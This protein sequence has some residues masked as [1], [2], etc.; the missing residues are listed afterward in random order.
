MILNY[1]KI[2]LRLLARSP[3]Y[4][5]I[6]L[7]GLSVG[8]AV[9][10]VLQQYSQSQLDSDKQWK[11]AERIARLGF[12]WEWTDDGT[13][14]DSEI[15]SLVDTGS[16]VMLTGDFPE[17]ES[18]TRILPQGQFAEAYVGFGS[19][20]ITA[21]ET[22]NEKR[23]FKEEHMASADPNV[24]E[25][26]DIPF[27]FG[28]RRTA[29]TMANA[30]VINQSIAKKYFGD[31][32]PLGKIILVNA[33][34]YLVAGVF[35]DFP[36]NTHLDF[37]LVI[38]NQ[39]RIAHWNTNRIG[40]V[41]FGYVKTR[42]GVDWLQFQDNLNNPALKEK[43]WAEVSRLFPN[44]RGK[45]L[46]ETLADIPFSS[47]HRFGEQP[48]K[49][50]LLLRAFQIIGI[51]V[52]MLAIINYLS[53]NASRISNRFKEIATR[54]VSGARVRDFFYQ[55]MT[56]TIIV[57]LIAIAMALTIVQMVKI[58]F[59]IWLQIP[60]ENVST[61]SM[62]LLG[63]V[64][65]LVL[66]VCATYPSYLSNRFKPTALLAKSSSP[67]KGRSLL[68]L[69]LFQYAI[70]TVLLLISVLFFRQITFM[71][72][73]DLGFAKDRV[74]VI[75]A[76]LHR[77]E[78]FEGNMTSFQNSILRKAGVLNSTL[79]STV[80]GD[81][82]N[83]ITVRQRGVEYPVVLDG[84]GG[85]DEHFIPC[86]ELK[87]LAGRNFSPEEK[88]NVIIISEGALSRLGYSD[89]ASAIGN[90]IDVWT[91]TELGFPGEWRD[92]EI[93]GVVKGYRLRPFFKYGNEYDKADR[94]MALTY[95][96]TV[97]SALGPERV[98]LRMAGDQFEQSLSEIKDTFERFFPGNFFHWYFLDDHISRHYESQKVSRNQILFFTCLAIAIACLGLL[99]M[100]SNKVIEKTKE[101]GIR[102][103]LGAK[104]SNIAAVLLKS[105]FRQIIL[106][107]MVSIPL[108]WYLGNSY[109]ENFTE[110]VDQ[111]WWH[112]A[113]PVLVLISIMFMTI[114]S[115]V[116]KAATTN[117]VES[118]RYE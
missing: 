45:F 56:E 22:G 64:T 87:L 100:I 14:W 35:A 32:D 67:K 28:D 98:T 89:P 37:E 16:P 113:L 74:V 86:Y 27:L 34:A 88:G 63:I 61:G 68:S 112:Y 82:P 75:D 49:S 36:T 30:I 93:I 73:K 21:V 71:L 78:N 23:F 31:N 69:S 15:F 25:F 13:T 111:Q 29:L 38:S 53:L 114:A 40:P 12:F 102:K 105:T 79:S 90:R 58:P 83:L 54:K 41:C 48:P 97:V 104:V 33:N 84:N 9:F 57:F 106:S 77:D 66:I 10:F 42:T 76:P 4:T 19:R 59:A 26:F 17:V 3:F 101:I 2:A 85:V 115:L 96:S 72:N 20:V 117:P 118:L 8:F 47:W 91:A 50:K 70:A 80:M 94:G 60:V 95:K 116:W 110:H 103:V 5:G 92:T 18:F 109:L 43:Y 52:L 107:L 65:L 108:A 46:I 11:D 24:F 55:F 7:F 62:I 44:G 51:V 39:A 99:G 81:Q 1:I 6:N